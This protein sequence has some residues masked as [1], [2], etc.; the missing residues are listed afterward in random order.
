MSKPGGLLYAIRAEGTSL[1]KIG[2]TRGSVEKRI[3]MLQTGQPFP[4]RV[5]ATHPIEE[6]V[7]QTEAWLHAFLK[8][9]RRSG[10]W[11]DIALDPET[12]ADLIAH[13]IHFGA[14]QEAERQAALTRLQKAKERLWLDRHPPRETQ[15]GFDLVEFGKRLRAARAEKHLQQDELA[16]RVAA[17]RTW[18]SELE[19][20]R[21]KSL[22]AET[23]VRF[24]EALGVSTDYLLGLADNPTPPRRP[25]PRPAG[26]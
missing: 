23:V 13:A 16:Q 20:G 4:L 1:V 12:F 18:I 21:Q 3:K 9:E 24:A 19:H 6:D 26:A 8:Q 22:R 25:R 2:Y 7:R 10:E 11:F 17:S 5:I 14:E 15:Y